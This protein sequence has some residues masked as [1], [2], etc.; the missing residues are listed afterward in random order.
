[1]KL[2]KRGFRSSGGT[3][4][5]VWISPGLKMLRTKGE[6]SG[7]IPGLREVWRNYVLIPLSCSGWEWDP[8]QIIVDFS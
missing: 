3:E 4:N 6:I 2:E 7:L 5:T 1:M 8:S